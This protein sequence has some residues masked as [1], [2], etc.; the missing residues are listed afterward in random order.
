MRHESVRPCNRQMDS[1]GEENLCL[2][3]IIYRSH[4]CRDH[5]VGDS[6]FA[7]DSGHNRDDRVS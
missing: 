4:D 6:L 5:L 7:P 1:T 2:L 3:T